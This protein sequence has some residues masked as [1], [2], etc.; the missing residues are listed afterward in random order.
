LAIWAP[1]GKKFH[2]AR[3][4]RR[5]VGNCFD[6]GPGTVAAVG[7]DQG[8][9]LFEE[10]CPT[11]LHPWKE[12]RRIERKMD[13]SR[14]ATNP[15]CFDEKGRWKKGA[16]ARNRSKRYQK[17]AA[18]RKE[19]ERRLCAERRRAHGEKKNRFLGV[20]TTVLTEANSYKGWQRGKFGKRMKVQAPGAFVA[21]FRNSHACKLVEFP[22]RTTS[23]SQFNHEDGTYTKKPLRQRHHEFS[24]GSRVQRDLYSAC[25][26]NFVKGDRLDAKRAA[27]AWADGG[28]T[29]LAA[30]G[31]GAL[32]RAASSEIKTPSGRSSWSFGQQGFRLPHVLPHM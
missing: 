29:P 6:I 12:L 22:T 17:L 25:L 4:G 28:G 32:L 8:E 14:R 2:A 11:V 19:R 27:A 1:Q 3:V 13:R 18:K 10:I 5:P 20:G 31:V 9:A 26:G 23:L 30:V 15:E 21:L 24:D 7:V 16:K